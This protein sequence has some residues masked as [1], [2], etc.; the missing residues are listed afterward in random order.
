VNT[1]LLTLPDDVSLGE[2][3]VYL[4]GKAE[5]SGTLQARRDITIPSDAKVFITLSQEVCDNMEL[6]DLIPKRLLEN[7]IWVADK[8][9]DHSKFTFLAV[10]QLRAL[11]IASSSGLTL[12]QLGELT[13]EPM[14]EHLALQ[15]TP[16]SPREYSWIAELSQLK[17]LYL[18]GTDAD[19]RC[20]PYIATLQR[21][22]SLGLERSKITDRA[23]QAIWQMPRI[24]NVG[25]SRCRIGNEALRGAGRCAS[26]IGLHLD[27]TDVGDEGIVR[28]VDEGLQNGQM[29]S[30]LSLSYCQRITNRSVIHL[31]A[32]PSMR[33]LS[34]NATTVSLEAAS[35]L[36]R[37]IPEC[38][39]FTSAGHL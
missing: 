24:K 33:V 13:R 7:G 37:C 14:L 35:Y 39:I 11:A 17:T 6:L 18:E 16:F 20:L 9:L 34:V 2:I 26:L 30:L 27:E 1:E 21:L 29:L 36:K 31:A 25:L 10:L 32:V 8:N 22:E 38:H 3:T 15:H 19:D 23:A 4:P 5:S 12:R 28:L